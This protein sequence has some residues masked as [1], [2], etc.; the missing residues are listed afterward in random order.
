MIHFLPTGFNVAEDK[1]LEGM[2][3]VFGPEIPIF[4]ATAGDNLRLIS[5]FQFMGDKVIEKGAVAVGFSDPT[6]E[7]ITQATH[8]FNA[9]G[10]PF[11]VTRSELNRIYEIEG[12][13][14]WKFLTDRMGIPETTPFMDTGPMTWF[15]QELPEELHEEYGN[16]HILYSA[17]GVFDDGSIDV[18]VNC[19]EGTKLLNAVRDEERMF[20]DLDKMVGHL[21]ERCAGREPYAVFHADCSAR[22]RFSLDR[23]LKEE[24]IHRMQLPL[25][26]NR[27]VPWLG[28]YGFGEFARL[29][30]RNRFHVFTTSLFIILKK[31]E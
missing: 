12:Q 23:V 30:D 18:Q 10:E 11:E 29:G 15:A 16:K 4:G 19:P 28:L 2:E 7:V 14:A 17:F 3:S 13:P 8:G 22:G 5:S 31:E 26:Q 1:A 6:I 25:M 24:Y 27:D 20:E 21:I 9:M